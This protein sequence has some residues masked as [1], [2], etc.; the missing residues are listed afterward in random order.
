MIRR[1]VLGIIAIC[2]LAGVDVPVR[3]YP[4]VTFSSAT[5]AFGVGSVGVPSSPMA[6]TVSN[7][8]LVPVAF[9]TGITGT[10][11]ADFAISGNN[12]GGSIA[13]SATCQ[14]SIVFTPS[15]TNDELASLDLTNLTSSSIYSLALTGGAGTLTVT[16]TPST[17]RIFVNQTAG[18]ILSAITAAWSDG[19]PFVGTLT[20]TSD[21][22]G[23]CQVSGSNVVLAQNA[24]VEGVSTC[25]VT[26]Q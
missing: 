17:V 25:T 14:I 22:D 2:L 13:P 4:A 7:I 1:L 15:T 26:A 9:S 21:P 20:I 8:G 10:N 6:I 12:C 23:L 24:L 5:A 19:R 3:V 18:A 16:L 11:G